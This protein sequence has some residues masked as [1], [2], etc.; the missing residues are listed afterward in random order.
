MNC[1]D[2]RAAKIG[3]SMM[4]KKLS[5]KM[6][7]SRA[8]KKPRAMSWLSNQSNTSKL[9]P[10]TW[11]QAWSRL[12]P[13][14]THR[15]RALI[16]RR[17]MMLYI[18]PNRYK[19]VIIM[20]ASRTHVLQTMRLLDYYGLKFEGFLEMSKKLLV[21]TSQQHSKFL[22]TMMPSMYYCNH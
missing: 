22:D 16:K 21:S 17:L 12:H 13:S 6:L 19:A 10:W 14:P 3:R 20:A 2:A 1:V 9:L 18:H 15:A 11:K 5:L 4:R 7:A 8:S